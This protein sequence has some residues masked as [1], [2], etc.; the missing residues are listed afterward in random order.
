MDYDEK[1]KLFNDVF[2]PKRDEK[3][4]LLVDIPHDDIKDTTKWKERREM[5]MEWYDT[6][7]E[8]GEKKGFT[9]DYKQYPATGLHNYII[10]KDIIDLALKSN[11][12]IAMTEFSASSSLK[13][14]A[15]KSK[16]TRCAS[17][18]MVERRMEQTAFKADYSEVQKNAKAI[19]KILN[20]AISADII[21]S[22][23]DNLHIDLRNR[24]AYEE[25]GDCSK[26][27]QM[28]NFPSGEAFKAPYEAA[29]DEIDDF[30]KS[31]T[32]G[33]IPLMIDTELIKYKIR[34]NKIV[35][36]IGVG[37]KAEEKRIFYDKNESRK[38]IAELGIGCNPNAVATGNPL[39]DEKV[40]GLHIGYGMSTHLGGKVVSDIHFDDP[41]PKN[42]PI[43]VKLLKIFYKDRTEITLIKNGELQY[44]LLK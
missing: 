8:L 10:P 20:N 17:M 2:V 39:E 11:L 30:G 31:K 36:I 29:S 38:N 18:P 14:I 27:G 37:K 5:A 44:H 42:G 24:R 33:V 16:I 34:E 41:Y 7:K 22:T 15:K 4:L 12:V 19:K 25:A 21:F 1:I 3:I 32:E 13:R 35:D 9:V 6:F 40:I 26:P 43:Q 23:D 28:I